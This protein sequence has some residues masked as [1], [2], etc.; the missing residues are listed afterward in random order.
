M[1]LCCRDSLRLNAQILLCCS[2]GDAALCMLL[3]P[4]SQPPKPTISYP[5]LACHICC[6]QASP[7]ASLVLSS[8]L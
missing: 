7:Y 1:A 3:G 2:R 4:I 8:C 5:P 6:L